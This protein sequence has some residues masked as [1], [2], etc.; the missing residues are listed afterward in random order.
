M[1]IVLFILFLISIVFSS[2]PGTCESNGDCSYNGTIVG[3]CFNQQCYYSYN[4]TCMNDTDCISGVCRY[5]PCCDTCQ[6]STYLAGCCTNSDCISG[7][8]GSNHICQSDGASIYSHLPLL[9]T[10]F[11]ICS[12]SLLLI[13]FMIQK[14]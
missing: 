2:A 6:Q 7:I 12:I 10:L 9:P 1:K 11:T 14:K 13:D 8:C 3:C 4:S 5:E